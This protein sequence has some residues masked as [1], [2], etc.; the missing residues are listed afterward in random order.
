M[1]D[2]S[3]ELVFVLEGLSPHVLLLCHALFVLLAACSASGLLLRELLLVAL[4]LELDLVLSLTLLHL[5]RV[6]LGLA[7]LVLDHLSLLDLQFAA[8]LRSGYEAGLTVGSQRLLLALFL[9]LS[10]R[11][12]RPSERWER[13]RGFT[14]PKDIGGVSEGRSWYLG[15]AFEARRVK[16]IEVLLIFLGGHFII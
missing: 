2:R 13:R 16:T 11:A 10:S 1:L 3:L 7:L 12:R 8:K 15:S 9:R 6:L 5:H 14:Q 4:Q